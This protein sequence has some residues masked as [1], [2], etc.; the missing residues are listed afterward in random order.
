MRQV[1]IGGLAAA[2]FGAVLAAQGTPSRPEPAPS[3]PGGTQAAPAGPRPAA[4]HAPAAATLTD[5]EHTALV[6][7]YCAGCH[8]A[9]GKA[10]GLSLAGFDA[11]RADGQADVAEKMIR[12]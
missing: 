11:A 8:S 6:G 9:R 5:A 2:A 10:G 12:K 3:L 7:Q 4:A 1:L